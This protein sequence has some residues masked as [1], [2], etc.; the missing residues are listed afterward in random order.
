MADLIHD[1]YT[2]EYPKSH[3]EIRGKQNARGILEDYPGSLPNIIAH[4]YVLSGDLDVT[5]M[6]LEYG[7]SRVYA[8]EV[9][10]FEDSLRHLSGERGG[11]NRW[12][13]GYAPTGTK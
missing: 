7:G 9:I 5:K 12:K 11:S 3:E 4:S 2:E 8:C 6:T 10:D 1:D 13:P